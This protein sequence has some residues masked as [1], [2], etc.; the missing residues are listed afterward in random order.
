VLRIGVTGGIGSGKSTV[1]ALLA[2][3]GGCDLIDVDAIAKELTSAGGIAIPSL[4]GAFGA[5]MIDAPGG[6]DRSRVQALVFADTKAKYKLEQILHPLIDAEATRQELAATGRAVVFDVPLLIESSQW[7]SRVDRILV[8]DCRESTQI[9][10]A[11]RRSGW[12]EDAVR[13]V[14]AQQATRALRC[15][16]AD[17]VI[18]NDGITLAQLAEKVYALGDLWFPAT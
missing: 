16:Y 4:R 10:R 18:C 1:A 13:A 14:I 6:L 9:E 12:T 11:V 7:A 5:E 2:K 15:Q 17:A 3:Q 8:V